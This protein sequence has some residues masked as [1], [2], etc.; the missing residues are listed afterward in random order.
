MFDLLVKRT[1]PDAK[2]PE[3]AHDGEDLGYD[4]FSVEDVEIAP[5]E[6]KMIG[7][8]FMC[9]VES[10][11]WN[12]ITFTNRASNF[13][14]KI[15]L[16]AKQP[17]GLAKKRKLAPMAGVIDGGF[18]DDLAII[19]YNYGDITQHIH[20]KDKIAQLVPI[21]VYTGKVIDIGDG[22]L[23]ESSRGKN[24]WGSNHKDGK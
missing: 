8:G 4:V 22:E 20:V 15:G 14:Q 17:S 23:S 3:V 19:L 5:G 2:L 7:L 12:G 21:P 18:R 10:I 9:E 13:T 1:H 24:G 6:Q 16:I 11:Y